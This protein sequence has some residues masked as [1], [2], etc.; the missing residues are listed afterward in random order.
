MKYCE[1]CSGPRTRNDLHLRHLGSVKS[2][3]GHLKVAF[4]IVGLVK[5]ILRR[6]LCDACDFF[7]TTSPNPARHPGARPPLSAPRRPAGRRWCPARRRCN[8]S[9]GRKR[10]GHRRRGGPERKPRDRGCEAQV[11][12]ALA[13]TV[14][15]GATNCARI[16][17]KPTRPE[18]LELSDPAFTLEA[19]EPRSAGRQ[20]SCTVTSRRRAPGKRTNR[21]RVRRRIRRCTRIGRLGV[22]PVPGQAPSTPGTARGLDQSEPSTR[23]LRCVLGCLP[24]RTGIDVPGR[25]QRGE[26][27]TSAP[28][29]MPSPCSS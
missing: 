20:R 19:G 18:P 21:R 8:A 13:R 23:F 14:E 11:L 5:T 28:M 4:G 6:A 10:R 9:A 1:E 12:V 22:L 24:R 2:N 26:Q 3:I 17:T 16:G 25:R 27:R 29:I 7:T 15:K